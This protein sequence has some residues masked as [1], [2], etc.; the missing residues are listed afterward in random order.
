MHRFIVILM[1]VQTG[2]GGTGTFLAE[3]FK[4]LKGIRKLHHFRFSSTEPGTVYVKGSI[5][6][7]EVPVNILKGTA[8]V[9]FSPPFLPSE[10]LPAGL[11]VDRQRYQFYSRTCHT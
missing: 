10:L 11:T 3:H 8:N 9:Q 2:N 4:P 1:E 6:D 7:T 5:H